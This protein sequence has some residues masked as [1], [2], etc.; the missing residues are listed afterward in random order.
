[1]M[2]DVQRFLFK[3]VLKISNTISI[4]RFFLDFLIK[5]YLIMNVK[6]EYITNLENHLHNRL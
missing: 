5:C 1:M 2:L 3:V 4:S 6:S